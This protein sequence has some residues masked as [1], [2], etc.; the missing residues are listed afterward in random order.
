MS[1][2]NRWTPVWWWMMD[3]GTDKLL[4]PTVYYCV[5]LC[6]VGLPFFQDCEETGN[7]IAKLFYHQNNSLRRERAE[8]S[9]HERDQLSLERRYGPPLRALDTLVSCACF[10]NSPNCCLNSMAFWTVVCLFSELI[11]NLCLCSISEC[12]GI[13][14][15]CLFTC[16]QATGDRDDVGRA[17]WSCAGRSCAHAAWFA[18]GRGVRTETSLGGASGTGGLKVDCN[19]S[20]WNGVVL[21]VIFLINILCLIFLVYLSVLFNFYV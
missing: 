15:C 16:H 11:L 12:I 17:G 13:L 21:I 14:N 19:G 2:Q 18:K 3:D 9:T 1:V 4:C 7:E 10:V 8:E 5:L 20:V 6:S